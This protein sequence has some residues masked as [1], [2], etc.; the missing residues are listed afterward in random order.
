MYYLLQN[1]FAIDN[2]EVV[3]LYYKKM[4]DIIF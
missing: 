3:K 1:K 4:C 2:N